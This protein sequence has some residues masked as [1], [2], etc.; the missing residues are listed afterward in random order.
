M[1]KNFVRVPEDLTEDLLVADGWS[2]C[3]FGLYNRKDRQRGSAATKDRA[4]RE[5]LDRHQYDDSGASLYSMFGDNPTD[6]Q[7]LEALRVV[8]LIVD[9]VEMIGKLEQALN[10]IKDCVESSDGRIQSDFDVIS[11]T[12]ND[13][14][15]QLATDRNRRAMRSDFIAI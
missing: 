7:L 8:R 4:L 9:P 10:K 2:M 3:G 11:A 13:V 15:T 12:T 14:L 1:N 6:D 5:T